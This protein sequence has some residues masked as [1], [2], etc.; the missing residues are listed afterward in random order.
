MTS[1]AFQ[2]FGNVKVAKERLMMSVNGPRITGRQSLM[3]RMMTLSGPGNLLEGIDDTI[4]S[5]CVTG[6]RGEIK[7]FLG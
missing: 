4:C 3:M 1:D 6:N 7:E 5:T 2:E